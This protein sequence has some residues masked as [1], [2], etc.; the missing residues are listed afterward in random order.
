MKPKRTKEEE[1]EFQRVKKQQ[2]RERERMRKFYPHLEIE[3]RRADSMTEA[4]QRRRDDIDLEYWQKQARRFDR[5]FLP[6]ISGAKIHDD[7]KV[8]W[9]SDGSVRL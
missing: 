7:V 8:E 3:D 5:R 2:Q 9:T 4:Q 6:D 1:R